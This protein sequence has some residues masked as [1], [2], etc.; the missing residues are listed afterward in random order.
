[1]VLTVK[2]SIPINSRGFFL[3]ERDALNAQFDVQL[4]FPKGRE[5]M[6][7]NSQTMLMI[8]LQSKIN[9]MMPQVRRIL[10]EAEN[11][12]WEYKERKAAARKAKEHFFKKAPEA[13]VQKVVVPKKNQNPF[14]ALDGLFE[15]EQEERVQT[16]KVLNERH[17]ARLEAKEMKAREKKAILDGKAPK[18]IEAKKTQM[19][20]AAAAAKPKLKVLNP[21]VDEVEVKPKVKLILKPAVL[22]NEQPKTFSWADLADDSSD[23]ED[24]NNTWDE[25]GFAAI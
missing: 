22:E 1:M 10:Q 19:N 17:L 4:K 16:L 7:G 5:F 8:G 2:Q 9:Q 3:R 15:Q 18:A 21:V 13:N 20:F 12:Y 14:A 6:F 25:I 11:Q 23:D 24:E